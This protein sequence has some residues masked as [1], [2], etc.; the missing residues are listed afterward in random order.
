MNPS[1]RP[2]THYAGAVLLTLACTAAALLASVAPAV[3]ETFSNATTITMPDPDCT[4]PHK[5]NPYPSNISVSGLTGTVSDVNVTLNGVTHAFQ[6]DIEVLLA[7]PVSG[8]NLTVLSDAGT[9]ALNNASLTFDDS[10]ASMAPQNVAWAPGTYK[11]S[12]YTELSGADPFPAPAPTPSS[13]STLDEAFDGIA[14]NG[15]WSLYV[16]DDAC[17]DAGSISGGWTLTI[18]TVSGAGTS[19]SVTSSLNPSRTGQSVTFTATVTS[20]GNPVTTGTVTFKDGATILAANQALNGSGQATFTTNSLAEGNH[21]ITATYNGTASF[22]TSSGTVDQRVDNNS[23]V[24]GDQYCNPG[25]I[26]I[27]DNGPAT[28]YPSNIFVSGAPTSL[29]KVTVTLKNISHTFAGDI[30]ALLVGPAGQNLVIASDASTQPVSNVT[31]TFDDAASSQLPVTAA[32]APAGSTI[33]AKPTNHTELVAD[34]FPAPA[35]P[36]SAATT[37]DTFNAT[38]ANGTWS[39]YV[40]DDGAPDIG[41]I[42]GGWCLNLTGDTTPP[43]VTINQAAGQAGTTGVAPINFTATFS[44]AV[45][46][47]TGSDVV[48]TG[49]TAGGTKTATVTGGPTIYNVEVTGMTTPGTVVASIPAG[50]AVDL[51]GNANTASTSTD[52]SV[53]WNPTTFSIDDITRAEGD[54]GTQVFS[55]TI[56]RSGDTSAAA[57]VDWSTLDGSAVAPSDYTAVGNTTVNFAVGETTKPALVTVNGDTTVEANDGFSVK[58]ANPVGGTIADDTG[59]GRITNDDAASFSVGDATV[60]EGDA[61]T[62][63]ATFTV[64]RSGDT[65]DAATVQWRTLDV[66]ATGGSD[67][68]A[69]GPTTLSFAAGDVSETVTVTVNGDMA[70]EPTE[71][72]YVRLS[73][74]TGGHTIADATGVGTITNDDFYGANSFS[75]TDATVAEGNSATTAATFT[76]SRSGDISKA[77]SVEVFTVSGTATAGVDYVAVAPTTVTFAAGQSSMPVSVTVNG[78]T[79]VEANETFTVR[80]GSVVG[81]TIADGSGLGRITNDDTTTF[82]V[83]DVTV[84]E[85]DTGSSVATFTVTRSG[86]KGGTATV[87]WSTANGTA[88]AASGD[89]VGVGATTLTFGPGETTKSVLVTVN[90]DTTTEANETFQ[91]VLTSPVGA[92]LGDGSGLGRITNDD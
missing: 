13:F 6:G 29:G 18:T 28:P 64:T 72:F 11:P 38:N 56:T 79:V 7:S 90:G 30:E 33:S 32:W 54:A 14:P 34:T 84:V 80:L 75:I 53:T 86:A 92:S 43:T 41:S 10:A 63:L 20:A 87:Q 19:T 70:V 57:S 16:L 26:A 91:V 77:A 8:R 25:P 15:T 2:T 24:T 50:A 39:L 52:N 37:L 74:P 48:F 82:S 44:E 61:G 58:L 88:T 49:S 51:G 9:G 27:N 40:K 3:A 35:P 68:V 1:R 69:V 42:A 45:T 22:N 66:H 46:G 59:V 12:N 76:V 17:P 85:G 83:D 36:P 60:T 62:I 71:D 78:D 65:G 73:D 21:V 55:F 23:T 5:A 31:V 67:F 89:Y 81:A 4:G 47:F